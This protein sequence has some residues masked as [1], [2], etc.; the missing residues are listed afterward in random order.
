VA[1]EEGAVS[2]SPINFLIFKI[3]LNIFRVLDYLSHSQFV[4]LNFHSS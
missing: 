4:D 1:A 3:Y 2:E